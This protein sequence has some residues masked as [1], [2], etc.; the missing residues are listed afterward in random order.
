MRT[1]RHSVAPARLIAVLPVIFAMGCSSSLAQKI[2][3]Q[4]PEQTAGAV[5]PKTSKSLRGGKAQAVPSLPH[6]SSCI[7]PEIVTGASHGCWEAL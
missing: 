1:S 4:L 3:A 2:L 6:G 7:C 5:A